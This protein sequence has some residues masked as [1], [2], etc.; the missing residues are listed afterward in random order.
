MNALWPSRLPAAADT[1]LSALLTKLRGVV[2]TGAI[3]GKQEVRLLLPADAWI[4][5]EAATEALHRATSAVSQKDWA[6]AWGAF[7]DSSSYC[8]ARIPARL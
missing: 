8:P 3:V 4:D 5:L 6:R 1:A 2:G 7:P